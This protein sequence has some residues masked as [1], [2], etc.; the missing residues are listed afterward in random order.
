MQP[1]VVVDHQLATLLTPQ[2]AEELAVLARSIHEHGC[3][4]PLA[5]WR[6]TGILLDGHA[7]H[8]ICVEHGVPF[9]VVE[10]DLP[11]R[12]AAIR[13]VLERQLGRRN[14]RPIA[15]SYFRGKLYLSLRKTV[16][17]PKGR[18][19]SGHEVPICTDDEVAARYSVDPRTIR[20]DAA[21]ARDLELLASDMGDD[22]RSSVLSGEARLNRKDVRTL[23][24]MGRDERRRYALERNLTRGTPPPT[25]LPA[26]KDKLLARLTDLWRYADEQTRRA[27]LSTPEVAALLEDA[28]C[29]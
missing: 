10:V 22:F 14:L 3:R 13:F 24:A 15:A 20:R 28:A 16:G 25:P 12:E 27:F 7:R 23:A 19:K 9:E 26:A 2:T 18:P 11:D 8:L 17:R 5:V 29:S 21:F 1:N 6:G 4:E